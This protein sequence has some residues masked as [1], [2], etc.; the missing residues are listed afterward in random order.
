VHIKQSGAVLSRKG[1][2]F[3]F[4][5]LSSGCLSHVVYVQGD[6]VAPTSS[7]KNLVLT[8]SSVEFQAMAGC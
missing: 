2:I 3:S 4:P 8:F 6:L 7:L 5:A 1:F